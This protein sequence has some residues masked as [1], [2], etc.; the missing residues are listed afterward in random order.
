MVAPCILHFGGYNQ[1]LSSR[2]VQVTMARGEVSAKRKC[3]EEHGPSSRGH[4]VLL[5]LFSPG[6]PPLLTADCPHLMIPSHSLLGKSLY[7]N[8]SLRR[9]CREENLLSDTVPVLLLRGHIPESC[10]HVLSPE[11]MFFPAVCPQ[12]V[13]I[14]NRPV[15][16]GCQGNACHHKLLCASPRLSWRALCLVPWVFSV[17]TL[18]RLSVLVGTLH[19][20]HGACERD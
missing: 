8:S 11:S 6:T 15:H 12:V 3:Q 9:A 10:M 1:A 20:Q 18:S 16:G 19:R 4:E 13:H 7:S 17:A 14:L 5:P 2:E